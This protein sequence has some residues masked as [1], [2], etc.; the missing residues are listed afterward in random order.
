MSMT[1]VYKDYEVKIM[2]QQQWI[3]P[4]IEVFWFITW[5]LLFSREM[6]L[7]W[8]IFPSCGEGWAYWQL[9]GR[10]HPPSHSREN[11][12]PALLT[13]VKIAKIERTTR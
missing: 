6:N 10:E 12:P 5:K 7:L 4:K 9:E 3:Q 13:R 8:G 1:F 11:P 2:G